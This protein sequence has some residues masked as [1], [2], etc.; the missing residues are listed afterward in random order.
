[1]PKERQD[2]PRIAMP[3]TKEQMLTQL[4]EAWDIILNLRAE[5]EQLRTQLA[6]HTGDS[7]DV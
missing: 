3:E 6:I 5:N 1:M 4:S 2:K 7:Y